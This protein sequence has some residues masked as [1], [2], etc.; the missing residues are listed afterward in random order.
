MH[1]YWDEHEPP[2]VIEHS[3]DEDP[4]GIVQLGNVDRLA[5][6][7]TDQDTPRALVKAALRW[8]VHNARV[9]SG[10]ITSHSPADLQVSKQTVL[11]KGQLVTFASISFSVSPFS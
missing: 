9:F 1:L 2:L 10:S 8:R 5:P 3:E 4:C 6:S 7:S 11:N